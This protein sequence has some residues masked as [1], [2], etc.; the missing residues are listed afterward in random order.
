LATVGRIIQDRR[1]KRA[2]SN[3]QAQASITAHKQRMKEKET[4]SL[5]RMLA[6]VTRG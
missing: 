6:R 2:T 4:A 5:L 1:A 3:A